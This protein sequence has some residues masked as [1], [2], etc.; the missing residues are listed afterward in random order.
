LQD[1]EQFI[2]D[3]FLEFNTEFPKVNELQ[4]QTFLEE[5]F[6][7]KSNIKTKIQKKE[8]IY[9]IILINI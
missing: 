2:H 9:E 8:E 5:Y 6:E 3:L 7:Q 1:F 4:I